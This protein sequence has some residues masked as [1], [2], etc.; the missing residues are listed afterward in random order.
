MAVHVY[1]FLLVV[2]L[3]L[4]LARLGRLCWLPLQPFHSQAGAVCTTVHRLLKPRTPLDCPVC[5]LA[6]TPSPSVRPSS[7]PV[8]PW[9]E[10]KS[11][12]GAPK[13]I[14][15]EC[16]TSRHRHRRQRRLIE[17]DEVEKAKRGLGESK[18]KCAKRRSTPSEARECFTDRSLLLFRRLCLA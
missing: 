2:F 1:V 10:V 17:I 18:K 11:R 4:G 6:S 12:R 14:D 5:R 9:S 3:M 16:M 8:R 7:A 13:H 15:T